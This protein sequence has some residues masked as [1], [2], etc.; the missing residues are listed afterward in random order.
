[1][2]EYLPEGVLSTNP[3]P[4]LLLFEMS[5]AS[6]WAND[7]DIECST[8]ATAHMTI[9]LLGYAGLAIWVF[10]FVVF[11]ALLLYVNKEDLNESHCLKRYGFLYLGYE[12]KAWFWECVKRMQAFI[13]G[14]ISNAPMGDDKA[15]LTLY[16]LA[17]GIFCVLHIYCEPYDD[18]QNKLLDK[19]EGKALLAV[20]VTM[21]LIQLI[22][23]F[24]MSPT[25]VIL[26]VGTIAG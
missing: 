13:Y 17:S 8:T 25:N 12:I 6:R 24:Q 21:V 4:S 10:G 1:M 26:V 19:L 22:I 18:R 14:F 15:R 5:Y 20:F 11:C 9:Q 7:R 23:T 2:G 3:K 16:A